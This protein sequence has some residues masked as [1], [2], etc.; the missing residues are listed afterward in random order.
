MTSFDRRALI[1][2]ALAAAAAPGF[3][4]AQAPA[5]AFTNVRFAI[6]RNGKPFG[7]YAVAFASQGDT[8]TVTTNVAM[9]ARIA[10]LTVFDYR[11]RCIETWRNG[12]FMEMNSYSIRDKQK[13]LEDVVTAVR[14]TAGIRITDKNG[15]A[16]HS[17]SA[18][19]FTHWN[20]ATLRGPLF[21]P[22]TGEMLRVTTA[23]IGKDAVTLASGSKVTANRWVVRGETEIDEWYS[24]GGA[25]FGLKGV[26][27]DRSIL[28]YRR[29]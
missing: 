11:H 5:S 19:P 24:D 1:S 16:M 10:G 14:T 28:E 20:P 7:N 22:Q 15:S 18:H 6:L 25:W 9:M 4:L 29:V 27:P 2:G 23:S 26:L 13:D 8:T 12:V 17:A 3:A 21:N